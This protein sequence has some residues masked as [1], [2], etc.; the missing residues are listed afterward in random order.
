MSRVVWGTASS[1]PLGGVIAVLSVSGTIITGFDFLRALVRTVTA[2]SPITTGTLIGAATLSS[3]ALNENVT[4]LI[5]IWL[6]NLGEYLELVTL[7]RTRAA[8]RELLS[9]HDEEIWIVVNGVEVAVHPK[10]V[11]P[12]AIAIARAGRKKACRSFAEPVSLCLRARC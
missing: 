5:V 2:R 7:R 10:D 4:A 3:I 1:G 8:I 12:G 9:T 11:G 6:L